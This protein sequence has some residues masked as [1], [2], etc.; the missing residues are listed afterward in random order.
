MDA[1]FPS[2]VRFDSAR[3]RHT[4]LVFL[5]EGLLLR[6]VASDPLLLRYDVIIVDE[7]H[8]RGLNVDFLL[9]VPPAHFNP[10]WARARY[11]QV[12]FFCCVCVLPNE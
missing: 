8:E 10:P 11:A 6:Q 12:G 4:R 9:G 2:Q 1:R 7:V 3:T 5:T